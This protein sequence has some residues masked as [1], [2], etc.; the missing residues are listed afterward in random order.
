MT[1]KEMAALLYASATYEVKGMIFD[2][3]ITDARTRFGSV[4]V[5][6]TPTSGKGTQWVSRD[7]VKITSDSR[8]FAVNR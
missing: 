4:D 2:V 3:T 1:A 5:E 8:S 6:I 7:S